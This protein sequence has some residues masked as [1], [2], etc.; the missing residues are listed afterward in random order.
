MNMDALNL[1]MPCR[2][3]KFFSFDLFVHFT[4]KP[5]LESNTV[6]GVISCH[7][8]MIRGFNWNPRSMDHIVSGVVPLYVLLQLGQ[9]WPQQQV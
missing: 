1:V 6:F 2:I 7:L 8:G 5:E 4:L 9:S 3:L